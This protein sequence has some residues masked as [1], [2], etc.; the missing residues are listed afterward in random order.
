MLTS[1]IRYASR[2]ITRKSTAS[3]LQI[4]IILACW[5]GLPCA[6]NGP[7]GSLEIANIWKKANAKYDARRSEILDLVDRQAND[8]PFRAT[9]DSLRKYQTPLWYEDAKFGIFIHWGLYSVPA[10]ASEWYS[11]NMYQPGSPEFRHH[12]ETYGPQDKFGYK[13]F[14]PLF[15]AEKSARG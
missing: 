9:W 1:R 6:Q 5:K 7:I 12:L 11:R 2:V 14:I 13:D 4:L 3:A 10:F 15:K 8:G